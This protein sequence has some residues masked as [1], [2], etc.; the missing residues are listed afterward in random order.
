MAYFLSSSLKPLLF[1]WH[2][3]Q[4]LALEVKFREMDTNGLSSYNPET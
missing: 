2:I 4:M 1:S 3:I